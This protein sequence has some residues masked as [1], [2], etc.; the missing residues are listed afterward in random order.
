MSTAAAKA[1]EANQKALSTASRLQL[2]VLQEQNTRI[3]DL[4]TKLE[5]LH[6]E[7]QADKELIEADIA[8]RDAQIER[9]NTQIE[10]MIKLH[11]EMRM[12]W[13]ALQAEQ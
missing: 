2:D 8:A 1:A 7:L 6:E 11:S 5:A 9:M 13:E 3:S 12:Y 10:A 4:L